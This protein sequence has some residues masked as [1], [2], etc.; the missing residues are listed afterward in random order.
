MVKLFKRIASFISILILA[1]VLI[2]S[3]AKELRKVLFKEE[4][5]AG[6]LSHDQFDTCMSRS[7]AILLEAV[8]RAVNILAVGIAEHREK[9]HGE[10]H[11]K[12][13]KEI[14]RQMTAKEVKISRWGW[15]YS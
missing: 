11:T 2:R 7:K 8:K 1:H 9:F 13:I 12:E 6:Y 5:E 15:W 10:S 3:F 4:K 14:S